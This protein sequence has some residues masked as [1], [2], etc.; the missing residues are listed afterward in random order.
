MT[1]TVT[2][3]WR[4]PIKGI[5]CEALDSAEVSPE[6]AVH[7]DRAWALLHQDAPDTDEWQKRRNFL[8]VANGPDLARI[9]A[10]TNGADITLTH[11]TRPTLSF[12]PAT[13]P[14]ALADWVTPLWPAT[15]PA[16]GR[17]VRAPGHGMTDMPEPFISV[18]N[19]ASLRALSAATGVEMDARRFRINI[20]VDGLSPW[21]ET[22]WDI[23]T[24]LTLGDVSCTLALP[25]D[26]CAATEANPETGERDVDTLRHLWKLDQGKAFG[27]Y[28]N[29][30]APGTIRLGDG[31]ALA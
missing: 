26:R 18:G 7:G 28:L 31:V 1:A 21:E 16:P 25:I 6:G 22:S 30:D 14:T 4:H 23:G 2:H 19:L 29:V 24:T 10:E 20:W 27:L 8:V 9:H 17:L 5:G 3:I 12:D 15:S 13:D 11:P